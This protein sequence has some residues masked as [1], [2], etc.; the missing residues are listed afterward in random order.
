MWR[1]RRE[2]DRAA[3]ARLIERALKAQPDNAAY[4]DSMGWV[5]FN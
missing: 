1:A 3:A 5:L 2:L 4:L